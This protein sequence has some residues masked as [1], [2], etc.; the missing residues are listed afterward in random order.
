MKTSRY[1]LAMTESRKPVKTKIKAQLNSDLKDFPPTHSYFFLRHDYKLAVIGTRAG[2]W[3][4]LTCGLT[5]GAEHESDL[6]SDQV[7]TARWQ[8]GLVRWPWSK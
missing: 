3:L 1:L 5:A 8:G 7:E 6:Q 2:H 4:G